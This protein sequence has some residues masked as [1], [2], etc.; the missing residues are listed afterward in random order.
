MLG[1]VTWTRWS[2]FRELVVTFDNPLQPAVRQAASWNNSTRVAGGARVQASDGWTL[3]GGAAHETTPVPDA[4][5]TPRLPEGAHTWL[6]GGAT[7]SGARWQWDVSVTHLITPD[8][9]IALGDPAAGTLRGTVH[10]RLTIAGVSAT[11]RF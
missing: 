5:R 2:A 7:Y 3:R 11:L 10:W 8:A 9:P 4:T 6:A 1:D